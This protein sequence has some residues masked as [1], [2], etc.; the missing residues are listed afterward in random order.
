MT[1][2]PS[3][4]AVFSLGVTGLALL[5]GVLIVA[6]VL[7]PRAQWA[8]GTLASI[9]PRHARL[10]GL[11]E[12]EAQITEADQALTERLRALA[13]SA[14]TPPDRVGAELQQRLRADAAEAGFG[15]VGSQIQP[16]REFDGFEAV[17]VSAILE[18]SIEHLAALSERVDELRPAARVLA[19]NVTPLRGRGVTPT[20]NIRVELTLAVA[21]LVQ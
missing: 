17:A 11:R 20:R 12:A 9:E 16:T 6:S 5:L 15:V 4:A 10:L 8:A 7:V 14:A 19:L 2:R 13:Y 18:G 1:R 3:S 21:R